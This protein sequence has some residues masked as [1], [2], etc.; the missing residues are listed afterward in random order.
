MLRPLPAVGAAPIGRAR[1]S[2]TASA[3]A[4]VLAFIFA[5]ANVARLAVPLRFG[6]AFAAAPWCDENLVKPVQS[7]ID[8][9]KGGK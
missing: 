8:E 4:A 1:S 3:S 2:P 6:V 9:L 7:K 5:G